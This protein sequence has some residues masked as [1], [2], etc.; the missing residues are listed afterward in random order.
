MLVFRTTLVCLSFLISLILAVT[1]YSDPQFQDDNLKPLWAACQKAC[2]TMEVNKIYAFRQRDDAS[3]TSHTRL[4]VG[5]IWKDDEED[6]SELW[7]FDAYWF[8]MRYE[9]KRPTDRIWGGKCSNDNG[10]WQCQEGN[11]FKFKGEVDIARFDRVEWAVSFEAAALIAKND[12]Y[13]LATNNCKTFASKLARNIQKPP[14]AP[15]AP[16][17]PAQPFDMQ[18][19]ID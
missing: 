16:R 11:V 15:A 4:V 5:H 13:N 7:T 12:C 2:V 17:P 18:L 3:Y 9:I 6:D 14:P 19:V 1:D 10:N 8:D